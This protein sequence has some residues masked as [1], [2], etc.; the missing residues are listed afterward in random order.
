[1]SHGRL[2]ILQGTV[3][4]V[5]ESRDWLIELREYACSLFSA[6]E[7]YMTLASESCRFLTGRCFMKIRK[8]LVKSFSDILCRLS[9]SPQLRHPV[10]KDFRACVWNIDDVT[11]VHL[12]YDRFGPEEH[13]RIINNQE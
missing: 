3:D 5:M 1:L 11:I 13:V 12:V 7:N 8:G 4:A 10:Q 6:S 2:I 9:A